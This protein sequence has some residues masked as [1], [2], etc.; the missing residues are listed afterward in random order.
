ML[1]NVKYIRES[2]GMTQEELAAKAH[3]SRVA[4]ANIERGKTKSVMSKTIFAL[5]DA[6][7][8]T[9]EELNE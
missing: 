4:L 6:L 8:C 2:Q 3:I 5:C 1:K 9:A 7:G